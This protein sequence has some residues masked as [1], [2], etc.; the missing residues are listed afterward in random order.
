MANETRSENVGRERKLRQEYACVYNV[1]LRFF[2][3][4]ITKGPSS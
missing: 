4:G 2:T 1:G 3:D